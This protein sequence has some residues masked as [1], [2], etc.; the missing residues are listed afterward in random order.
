[1]NTTIFIIGIIRAV[2]I[3]LVL[4]YVTAYID[5]HKPKN[6][7]LRKFWKDDKHLRKL[8]IKYAWHIGVLIFLGHM[9][10][11]MICCD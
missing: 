7:I 11:A 6:R 4:R 2:L 1:M 10:Y 5:S 9:I 3:A 8:A